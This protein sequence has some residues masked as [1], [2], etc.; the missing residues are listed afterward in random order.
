VRDADFRERLDAI[1]APTLVVCGSADPVTTVADGRF[2]AE[3][4]AGAQLLELH[5]AHLSN[6]EAGEAFSQPVLAFLRN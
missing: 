6:V 4:I 2:M 1:Q 5:A 3:R